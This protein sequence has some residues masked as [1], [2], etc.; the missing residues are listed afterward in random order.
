VT[1]EAAFIAALREIATAPGARGLMDDAAVLDIGG[2]RL[3]LTMDAIVEGVH[4]LASD[5]PDSVAWK[6]VAMNVSDLCAKGARPRGCL[7]AYPLTA[8]EAWNEQ[9][10]HGLKEACTAFA[11]PLLGGDTVRQPAGSARSFS[12]VALGEART[13]VA[14]PDRGGA[15]PGDIIWVTGPIGDAGVGLRLLLGEARAR[16]RNYDLLVNRYRRPAPQ[17]DLGVALAVHASAMMD[18]SD[19]LL[20][21]ISRLAAAS[22]IAAVI[23]LD[24]VPLSQAFVETCG[25]GL[26][27]RRAAATAGDDYCL[28]VT[29]PAEAEAAMQAGARNAGGAIYRVGHIMSGRGLV[30]L[31][32][33]EP[34]PLPDRLGFE[35]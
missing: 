18:V 30:L 24:R 16:S 5:P 7:L 34:V 15:R 29:A 21:D 3:V 25:D 11:I 9:F 23:E 27:E 33:G 2:A 17:P 28:L 22:G 14:V 32:D 4:F 35:H 13:G 12:L 31:H 10:L 19:G 8:D 1:S 20:I 26:A 6:L